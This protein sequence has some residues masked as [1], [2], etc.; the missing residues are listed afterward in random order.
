MNNHLP[1]EFLLADNDN[2]PVKITGNYWKAE[3]IYLN[4]ICIAVKLKLTKIN[5]EL[6]NIKEA[7]YSLLMSIVQ[8]SLDHDLLRPVAG[9]ISIDNLGDDS[10][11]KDIKKWGSDQD[12]HR[13]AF[14][15]FIEHD[16]DKV[17]E[18]I[19]GLMKLEVEHFQQEEFE[20]DTT[21]TRQNSIPLLFSGAPGN[22]IAEFWKALEAI[23]RKLD[24]IIRTHVQESDKHLPYDPIKTK[25]SIKDWESEII[26]MSDKIAEG[27]YSG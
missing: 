9:V 20:S 3:E 11:Q 24:I 25:N 14:I 18:R 17:K 23:E 1:Q 16:E 26:S 8:T 27:E 12:W 10:L 7:L 15:L 22:N 2:K 13:G 6:E 4:N 19:K 21:Q 5:D